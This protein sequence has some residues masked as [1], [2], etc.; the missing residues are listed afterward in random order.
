M[1][2]EDIKKRMDSEKIFTSVNRITPNSLIIG[3]DES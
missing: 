1:K 2:L 3:Y